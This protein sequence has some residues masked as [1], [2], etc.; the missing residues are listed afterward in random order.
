MSSSIQALEAER[1]SILAKAAAGALTE[2]E[3]GRALAV[4]TELREARELAAKQESA[5][6]ALRGA[7]ATEPAPQETAGVEAKKAQIARAGES[8][9]LGLGDMFVRSEAY[10]AF[11]AGSGGLPVAGKPVAFKAAQLARLV[12]KAIDSETLTTALGGA[13]IPQRLPGITDLTYAKRPTLL[14]YITRGTT[15]SALLEY[16]QL[17]TLVAGAA[18]VAEGGKKPL[19]TLTT[20]KAQ[21]IA[22]VI[23]DGIKV[24]NQELADDGV[25][26]SLLNTILTRNI[27]LKLED[28]LLNGNGTS[29]PR[30]ILNTT[31]VLEEDFDTDILKTV[32]KSITTLEEVSNT[33][34]NVILLNPRDNETI[35]L[36]QDDYGRYYGNG[37]FQTGPGTLWGVPRATSSKIPQGQ[38]LIGD[39]SGVQLLEREPLSIDAFNQNEDDARHN[40]TYLRAETRA[41]LLNREPARQCLVSLVPGGNNGGGEGP[42]EGE[43]G[44]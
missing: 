24:T 10:K 27:L 19:T 43:G 39:L 21:A 1:E 6:D 41:L 2:D 28:L 11:R 16:R 18:V 17:L 13:I 9:G 14:D 32:R 29:E 31:G 12:A 7:I 44:E 30:G 42:G 36:I 26:A 33:I 34:P 40:L 37:P 25:I 38:A 8:L 23:A 22:H 20:G 4:S 3:V 5:L 15:E 35:D